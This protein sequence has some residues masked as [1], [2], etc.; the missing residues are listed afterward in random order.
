M[1]KILFFAGFAILSLNSCQMLDE[2]PRSNIDK[3]TYVKD[4]SQAESVLL[5]VYRGLSL[6]GTY[7][8]NLSMIYDLTTDE[9]QC[10]GNSNVNFRAIPSGGFNASHADIERTWKELYASI[11]NATDFIEIAGKN[12]SGFSEEDR[13]LTEYYIAEAKVLRALFYFDLVRWFGHIVLVKTTAE[14]YLPN[15]AYVQADPV[16]VYEFIESDLLEAARVLPWASDDLLRK[17]TS[18]RLSRGSAY[19][20]LMKVYATW[21]GYPIRDESKWAEVVRIGE[22]MTSAERHSLLPDFE[23]LWRDAGA[24]VWNPQEVLIAAS[25]FNLTSGTPAGRIGKFNGV[26]ADAIA[27]TRG[28]N[29][30]Y[31]KVLYPFIAEWSTQHDPRFDI[32]IA[33]FNYQGTVQ[34]PYSK[35]PLEN[36]ASDIKNWQLCTPGKWDTEKYVPKSNLLIDANFSNIS[37]YILRYA[38]VLLLYAEAINETKKAPDAAAY[39]A[40]N[41]VRRRG[42]G[43]DIRTPDNTVDL[44][45]GLSYEEFRAAIKRERSYELCFEGHRKQDLIRWG[46]YYETVYATSQKLFALYG[47]ANYVIMQYIQKGKNELM[48][49]P[50]REKDL[51]GLRQNDNW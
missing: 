46:E 7:G 5:G 18:Y 29:G 19:G 42:F 9:A 4:A 38:D 32:S 40:V 24:G 37:W 14:S 41:M 26:K 13:K 28:S 6:E 1:K 34:T 17:D 47:D 3:T 51:M 31:V 39:E 30:G 23:Q 48:P 11:Y 35:Q 21:A 8:Y 22:I 50:L 36:S 12:I 25:F 45:S 2:N 20:L 15:E 27:G 16:D 44:P 49:I 43:K 10:E 33:S